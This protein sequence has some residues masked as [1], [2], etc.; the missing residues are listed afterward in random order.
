[1]NLLIQLSSGYPRILEALSIAYK[2]LC[3][4]NPNSLSHAVGIVRRALGERRLLIK[5]SIENI[6]PALL[7][8][9]IRIT[10]TLSDGSGQSYATLIQ[11]G[12]FVGQ[13]Q[14]DPYFPFVPTLPL[15]PLY[16]W[17]SGQTTAPTST[18]FE[19]MK[20]CTDCTLAIHKKVDPRV[21][22]GEGFELIHAWSRYFDSS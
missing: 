9:E 21:F 4:E 22:P 3:Q 14:E 11:D 16:I 7:G 6:V 20:R 8:K 13:L 18:L 15:L 12:T 1:M 19:F 5:P 10:Y 2:D 17:A